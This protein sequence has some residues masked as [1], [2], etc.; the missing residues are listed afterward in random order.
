MARWQ[1][2]P[3]EC[4]QLGS[5]QLIGLLMSFIV[6]AIFGQDLEYNWFRLWSELWLWIKLYDL[7]RFHIMNAGPAR[8]LIV[9]GPQGVKGT[10][11]ILGRAILDKVNCGLVTHL[12][13]NGCPLLVQ[14]RRIHLALEYIDIQGILGRQ[15]L[16]SQSEKICFWRANKDNLL[17]RCECL[18]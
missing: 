1:V 5:F 15:L 3:E 17:G 18:G 13:L 10:T 7:C 6:A 11:D 14:C 16:G 9:T 4:L 2:L 8:Q 12:L